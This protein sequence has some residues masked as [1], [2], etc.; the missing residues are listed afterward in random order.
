[1][2]YPSSSVR[3]AAVP[4]LQISGTQA[5]AA[6]ASSSVLVGL[7]AA[8]DPGVCHDFALQGAQACCR[9]RRR[10]RLPSSDADVA[11]FSDRGAVDAAGPTAQSMDFREHRWRCCHRWH[12]GRCDLYQPGS[13]RWLPVTTSAPAPTDGTVL[14]RRCSGRCSVACVRDEEPFAMK[15]RCCA[16]ADGQ[17]P[18]PKDAD[19]R[20]LMILLIGSAARL[21]SYR[22]RDS[23][24]S[25]RVPRRTVPWSGPNY[26]SGATGIESRKMRLV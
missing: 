4:F 21:V 25:P 12:V 5:R 20:W 18:T 3:E 14:D 26:P 11:Q 13:R 19:P 23:N 2:S 22:R 10:C 16:L 15:W 9:S 6:G 7:C 17:R 8:L 24:S 1:M